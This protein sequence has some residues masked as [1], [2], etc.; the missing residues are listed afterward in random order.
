[1]PATA[2]SHEHDTEYVSEYATEYATAYATAYATEQE[3]ATNR[4]AKKW[5][6]A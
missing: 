6:I 5:E 2:G 3:S 1:M 4:R